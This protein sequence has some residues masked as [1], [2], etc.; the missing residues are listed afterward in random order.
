MP[1]VFVWIC[2][3]FKLICEVNSR[4]QLCSGS[5]VW[6]VVWFWIWTVFGIAIAIVIAIAI[7][8]VSGLNFERWIFGI[9]G[10]VGTTGFSYGAQVSGF[11][12]NCCEVG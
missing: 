6:R 10:S 9:V 7:G 3:T 8:W 4:K 1:A 2:A 12:M 5:L 11:W